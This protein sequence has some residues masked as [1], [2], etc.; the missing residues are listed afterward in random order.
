[1]LSEWSIGLLVLETWHDQQKDNEDKEDNDDPIESHRGDSN[2]PASFTFLSFRDKGPRR[3]T[4]IHKNLMDLFSFECKYEGCTKVCNQTNARPPCIMKPLWVSVWLQCNNMESLFQWFKRWCMDLT[5]T[6]MSVSALRG[7]S[8]EHAGN[9]NLILLWAAIQEGIHLI[10]NSKL[11]VGQ[12][13]YSQH[14]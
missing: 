4:L 2:H 7:N 9:Q 1:M 8:G 12:N 13:W 10:L 6:C 3:K 14:S 5:W 11:L